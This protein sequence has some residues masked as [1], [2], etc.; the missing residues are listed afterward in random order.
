MYTKKDLQAIREQFAEKATENKDALVVID[1]ILIVGD[2]E[3]IDWA[4]NR[5]EEAHNMGKHKA[6]FLCGG[7]YDGNQKLFSQTGW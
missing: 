4:V 1:A 7:V 2:S 3:R 5:L 6:V